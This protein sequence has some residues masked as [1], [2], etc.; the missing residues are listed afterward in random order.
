[1]LIESGIVSEGSIKGF[2]SGKHYNRSVLSHK[3]MYEALQRLRFEAFLDTLDE[4]YQESIFSL[5]MTMRDSFTEG[6]FQ[7]RMKSQ[8]CDDIVVKYEAFVSESSTKSKTFA[9]WSMYIKLTGKSV[10]NSSCF[11]S[12]LHACTMKVT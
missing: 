10:F 6:R 1:M 5:I 11:T 9:Y 2:L 7:E 4:E 3:T 12:L 8:L